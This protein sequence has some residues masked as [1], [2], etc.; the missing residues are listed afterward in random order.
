MASGQMALAGRSNGVGWAT[1][2]RWLTVGVDRVHALA[3]VRRVAGLV[4]APE[5]GLAVI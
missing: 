1:K 5:A 2:R 4:H 3:A